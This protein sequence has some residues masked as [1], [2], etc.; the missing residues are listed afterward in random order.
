VVQITQAILTADLNI[1]NSVL[2]ANPPAVAIPAVAKP[3]AGK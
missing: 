3:A 2:S 1:L